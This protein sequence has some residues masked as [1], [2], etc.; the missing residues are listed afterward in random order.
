[1]KSKKSKVPIIINFKKLSGKDA[2]DLVNKLN[3]FSDD[4]L[5]K[6]EIILA[7]QAPDA[8]LLSQYTKFKIF[9]QDTFSEKK[10]RFLTFFDDHDG[11]CHHN[12]KGVIL[13]HPERKLTDDALKASI[14]KAKQLNIETLI[15]ATT[16]GEAVEVN[17]YEP[18]YIGIE[19][20]DLIGKDDSFMN[21][22]PGIVQQAKRLINTDILIGA[23]IK[24]SKDLQHVLNTG[25][26]GV[27]ISS[28]ILKS[29]DPSH[30]LNDFLN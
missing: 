14:Q 15:C 10:N 26:S 22:C 18:R 19:S 25:G 11:S 28:L 23:G 6:Y 7:V 5:E 1:M 20:E 4:L 21:H 2:I 9:V 16:V 8:D 13:N 3:R 24:T 17:K 30:T 27:L 29:T 12:V